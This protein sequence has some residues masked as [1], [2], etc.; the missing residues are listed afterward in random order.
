[1]KSAVFALAIAA[2]VRADDGPGPNPNLGEILD[3][4]PDNLVAAMSYFPSSFI[5]GLMDGSE[6]LPTNP[7][8][9]LELA[10]GIP[11]DDVSAISSDYVE[12]ISKVSSLLPTPT[13]GQEDD[14][15]ESSSESEPTSKSDEKTT[16]DSETSPDESETKSE[17]D[18]DDTSSSEKD[19]D[20]DTKNTE[21][22]TKE[23][24]E[25]ETTSDDDTDT[26]SASHVVRSFGIVVAV[27]ASAALF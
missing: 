5:N 15:K 16:G 13:D 2:L 7:S 21:E 27:V 17:D 11:S 6:W 14:D 26:G 12:F 22:D 9:L 19:T 10:T 20:S 18:K 1:M 24:D 25:E 23:D 4:M 3:A 8:D